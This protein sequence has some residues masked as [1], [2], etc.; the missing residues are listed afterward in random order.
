[1]I[2]DKAIVDKNSK[3]GSLVEVGPFSIIGKEVKMENMLKPAQVEEI[4]NVIYEEQCEE[5]VK[6]EVDDYLKIKSILFVKII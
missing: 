6:N 1:M 3:L 2:S 4:S 5:E